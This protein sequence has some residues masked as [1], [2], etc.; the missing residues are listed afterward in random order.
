MPVTKT[1]KRALRSS[2]RKEYSNKKQV[3]KF[4]I[5]AWSKVKF[6]VYYIST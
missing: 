2:K 5:Q 3:A 1:A 4:E 6:K